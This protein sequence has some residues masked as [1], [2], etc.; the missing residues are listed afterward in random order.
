MWNREHRHNFKEGLLEKLKLAT[1]EYKEGHRVIW[2]E[3]RFSEIETK[4]RHRKY[5][6]N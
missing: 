3:A 1:H 5:K 4:S 6:I 2:D